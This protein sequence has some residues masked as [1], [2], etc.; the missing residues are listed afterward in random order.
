MSTDKAVTK[1]LV[2]T[3]EDGKNGFAKGAD[4][5]GELV[6]SETAPAG[7]GHTTL[8]STFRDFSEQR[9]SFAAELQGMAAD[10]GDDVDRSGSVAAVVHRGWMSLKD[11]LSSSDAKA[12]LDVAKQGEDHAVSEFEKALEEDISPELRDVV[13]RQLTDIRAARDTVAALA[14][15]RS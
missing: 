15:S 5:L 7:A 8:V 11:A 1:D 12:V 14:D 3:L 9:S 2:Q 6:Q 10:Y 4:K 13:Q